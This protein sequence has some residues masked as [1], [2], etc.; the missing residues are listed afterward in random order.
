MCIVKTRDKLVKFLLN[1]KIEVKIHYP[2]PL[3]QQKA[4]KNLN[5]NQNE[6]INV[7]SQAKSLITLPVHQYLTKEQLSFMVK[8]LLIFMIKKLANRLKKKNQRV[9]SYDNKVVLKPWGYEYVVYRNKN[10]LSLTLLNLDFG[11]KHHYT[12]ILEKSGFILIKGKA[13]FQL[14]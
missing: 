9:V 4:S 2:I 14:D 10:N 6:F 5:I 12:A 11:K 3:N 13:E 8:K 1:N 7:N